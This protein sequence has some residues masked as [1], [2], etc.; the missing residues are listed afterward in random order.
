MTVMPS[1][2]QTQIFQKAN[3]NRDLSTYPT[4]N[5]IAE[6]MVYLLN[7]PNNLIVKDLLIEN[8]INKT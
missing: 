4:P 3:D 7:M 2:V 1:S 6:M 5:Q 8:R